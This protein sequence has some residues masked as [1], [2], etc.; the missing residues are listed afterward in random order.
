MNEELS[1]GV[2]RLLFY[3]FI[4]HSAFIIC[5]FESLQRRVGKNVKINLASALRQ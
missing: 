2:N 3:F 1:A 4:L 5:I